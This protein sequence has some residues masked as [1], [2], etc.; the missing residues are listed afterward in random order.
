MNANLLIFVCMC[1]LLSTRVSGQISEQVKVAVDNILSEVANHEPGIIMGIVSG[2]EIVYAQGRGIEVLGEKTLLSPQT[3][4]FLSSISKEFIGVTI[5]QLVSAGKVNLHAPIRTYIPAFPSYE[6]DPTIY[7]VLHHSSGIKDY[8]NLLYFRGE[9]FEDYLSTDRIIKLL[10]KQKSLNF[11]PGTEFLY[12]NT[13]YEL[14]AEVISRVTEQDF[15]DYIR[16]T[17]FEPLGM[18]DTYFA[19]FDAQGRTAKVVGYQ[20]GSNNAPTPVPTEDSPPIGSVQ[21]ISTVNDM[22]RWDQHLTQN[23]F[24]QDKAGPLLTTPGK[25]DNGREIGYTSG[26]EQYAYKNQQ[27]IGHGGFSRGFQSNHAHFK[28]HGFSII[29]FSNSLKY[30]TD[31]FTYRVADILFR[32]HKVSTQT[33]ENTFVPDLVISKKESKPYLGSYY[34]PISKRER[35]IY[36]DAGI[37][38]YN[39]P[40][41]YASRL[42]VAGDHEFYLL[43]G[44]SQVMMTI[45]FDFDEAETPVMNIHYPGTEQVSKYY[46]FD[47]RTYK[48]K[49]LRQFEGTYYSEELDVSFE[50]R[51]VGGGLKLFR[52][53]SKVSDLTSFKEYTFRDNRL[54]GIFEFEYDE[55]IQ[56]FLLSQ[57]RAR[58]VYFKKQ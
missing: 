31:A 30:N 10:S 56:G 55:G 2:G 5:A 1:L 58:N 57:E 11:T 40:D 19:G 20:M 34:N 32:A 51:I 3:P 12:S 35:V 26:F 47:Y 16:E 39:R 33:D 44:S 18:K 15:R 36:R 4:F 9:V 7:Q 8:S 45:R 28:E 46:R 43:N 38:R 37:L 14:L 25:L 6:V 54:A 49:E 27:I 21:I 42:A 50:M 17:I 29:A 41:K 22:A 52:K 48:A 53:G 13:N 24:K 23:L